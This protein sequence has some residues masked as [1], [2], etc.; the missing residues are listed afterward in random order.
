M[1]ESPQEPGA[2]R[3]MAVLLDGVGGY[4]DAFGY[5]LLFQLFAANMSGNSILLGIALGQ[6]QW[7]AAFRQALPIPLF[8]GGVALGAVVGL[9]LEQRGVRR[10]VTVLLALEIALLVVFAL[11]GGRFLHDGALRPETAWQDI[12]LTALLTLPMG[13][14]N[15]ALR[16]VGGVSVYTTFVTG[17]LTSLAE[18]LVGYRGPVPQHPIDGGGRAAPEPGRAVLLLGGMWAA[19]VAGAGLGAVLVLRWAL[20][21]L[22]VPLLV[23]G[24]LTVLDLRRPIA[25]PAAPGDG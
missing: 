25:P 1:A 13:M 17:T 9:A 12:L 23:L 5:L 22:V 6:G 24:G 2:P 14:Q 8:F 19:Y 4:V 16:R 7:H 10:R 3:W 11:Y 21:A 15:V 20:G 18:T